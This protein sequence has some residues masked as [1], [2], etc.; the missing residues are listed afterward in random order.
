MYRLHNMHAC[1][2]AF[3]HDRS[4]DFQ[5]G[6]GLIRGGGEVELKPRGGGSHLGEKWT[7]VLYPMEPLAQGGG[8]GGSE[9][10]RAQDCL[11][12]VGGGLGLS[13]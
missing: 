1:T 9:D 11:R 12:P 5:R 6:W 10:T 13:T 2:L 7:C 3:I 8:G 4:Q